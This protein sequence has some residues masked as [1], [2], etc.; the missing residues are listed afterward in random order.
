MSALRALVTVAVAALGLA[1]LV[2]GVVM[3]RKVCGAVVMPCVR[4]SSRVLV[5]V[6]RPAP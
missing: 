1:W 3:V 4:S 6:V 2:A 5:P